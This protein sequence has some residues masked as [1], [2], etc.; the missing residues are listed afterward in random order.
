MN[1]NSKNSSSIRP[2]KKRSV[3]KHTFNNISNLISSGTMISSK[4]NKRMLKL[5]AP[6]K[7]G[8][9]KRLS[10][11]DSYWKKNYLLISNS[12]VNCLINRRCKLTLPNK[13]TTKMLT[14]CKWNAKRWSS[15]KE[16]NICKKDKRKLLPLKPS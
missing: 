16:K 8:T 2:S 10:K 11:I 4:P 12:V 15:T 9:L 6:S 5:L 14:R 3:N 1:K 13:K 7:T